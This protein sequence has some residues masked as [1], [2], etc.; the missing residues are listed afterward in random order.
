M[1][2]IEYALSWADP[3]WQ[4]HKWHWDDD[5]ENDNISKYFKTI[6]L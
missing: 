1:Q 2:E 6:K 3:T 4:N 5:H